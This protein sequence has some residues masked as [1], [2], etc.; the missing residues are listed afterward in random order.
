MPDTDVVLIHGAAGSRDELAP[1]EAVLPPGLRGWR[2][3]LLGH[4]GRPLPSR[5]GIFEMVD[6]LADQMA[7]AGI[8]KAVLF[9]YSLG[10]FLALH[11]ALRHPD[12]VAGVCT[13]GSQYI[14]DE[15]SLAHAAAILDPERLKRVGSDDPSWVQD[16][17]ICFRRIRD[18]GNS[19]EAAL[20]EDHLSRLHCP[21]LA[22]NGNADPLVSVD[23]TIRHAQLIPNHQFAIYNGAAHPPDALPFAL[24]AEELAAFVE[25]LE[26]TMPGSISPDPMHAR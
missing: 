7:T 6:D 11:H 13:L 26:R 19:H 12:Q 21:V 24:L 17:Y 16:L 9:G 10:G 1:L 22:I 14:W 4:G 20:R 15:A 5:F 23:S 3:N 18:Q 8:G 25:G 2:F